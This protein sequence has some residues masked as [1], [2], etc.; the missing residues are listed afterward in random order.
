MYGREPKVT[1]VGIPGEE[2]ARLKRMAHD[3]ESLKREIRQFLNEAGLAV[4]YGRK[5]YAE[6][7]IYW[8][9]EQQPDF[10]QF[11]AVARSAG[12]KLVV[13]AEERFSRD[14]IEDALFRLEE[15]EI[16]QE[17]ARNLENRLHQ[18]EDYEGFTCSL[19]LSFDVDSRAYFFEVRTD[20]YD[21]FNRIVDEI[22]TFLPD[23]DEPEED[24]EGLIGG[25]YSK[26]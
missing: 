20:W 25:Y 16:P 14:R 17:E 4:F 19:E 2:S 1:G 12:A 18:F 22:D 5:R 9:V 6:F 15:C 26:N 7:P 21:T 11:L 23:G 10:R 3:L 13:F 8:D 24:D